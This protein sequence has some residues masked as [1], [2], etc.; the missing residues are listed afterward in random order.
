MSERNTTFRNKILNLTAKKIFS[1]IRYLKVMF[2]DFI[3][4][5][6][7]ASENM[8]KIVFFF[9]VISIV[10]IWNPNNS[11]LNIK[12]IGSVIL[13]TFLLGMGYTGTVK[14]RRSDKIAV[15]VGAIIFGFFLVFR[16][17]GFLNG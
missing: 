9:I 13:G 5:F 8:Q 6:F 3:G 15:C 7:M 1:I 10:L 4:D 16:G 12:N 11:Q 17:L 14:Y 2:I